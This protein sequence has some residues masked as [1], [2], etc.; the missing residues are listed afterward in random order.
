M[1]IR[2]YFRTLQKNAC[3]E[4]VPPCFGPAAAVGGKI[5]N[6]R[7]LLRRALKTTALLAVSLIGVVLTGATDLHAQNSAELSAV[8]GRGVHAYFANQSDQAEQQ[9][10]QVI[11]AG[12]SDPRV[13]YF[14]A[15]T[16]LRMG[17][18]HEAANDMR[19]GADYEA[20]NPGS[21]G[22]ISKALERVQGHSRRKLEQ[23]R[24]QARLDRVQLRRHQSHARYETLQRREPRI[25]RKEVKVPLGQLLNPPAKIANPVDILSNPPSP[26][27]ISPEPSQEEPADSGED[28]FDGLLVPSQSIENSQNQPALSTPGEQAEPDFFNDVPTDASKPAPDFEPSVDFAT[29]ALAPTDKVE[30]GKLLGILGRVVSR[31]MPW[32]NIQ[33]P[34]KGPMGGFTEEGASADTFEFGPVDEA[35]FPNDLP[36][37]SEPP[38]ES[39]ADTADLFEDDLFGPSDSQ[40]QS[41][42]PANNSTKDSP[43][44]ETE[45]IPEEEEG[46]LFDGF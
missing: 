25:L 34:L 4:P 21:M 45:E 2:A 36:L 9:F 15:M 8:Y 42:P 40:P 11:Q 24:R 16:R 19:I 23:F 12:S 26:P 5:L 1:E 18:Q 46:G 7:P 13:F 44:S 29:P 30:S 32:S 38:A 27:T 28:L 33:L 39:P 3:L 22:S 20:R 31:A 14:R 43:S 17:R 6:N 10:T 35:S 41:S 37:S